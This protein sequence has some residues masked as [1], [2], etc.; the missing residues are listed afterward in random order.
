MAL[1]LLGLELQTVV[2]CHVGIKAESPGRAARALNHPSAFCL[3]CH[4]VE[5]VI[6]GPARTLRFSTPA[7]ATAL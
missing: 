1:D 6:P 3:P 5:M 7:H 4:V 2:S